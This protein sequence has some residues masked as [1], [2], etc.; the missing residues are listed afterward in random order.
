MLH[1]HFACFA[2][3]SENL[4]LASGLPCSGATS[5]GATV[6]L[7][8]HKQIFILHKFQHLFLNSNPDEAEHA[9]ILF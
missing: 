2:F 1:F 7:I 3:I 9:F 5:R 4:Q 6:C 8:H